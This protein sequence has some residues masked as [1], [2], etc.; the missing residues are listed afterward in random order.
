MQ[1]PTLFLPQFLLLSSSVSPIY[2]TRNAS[3]FK[4]VPQMHLCFSF[5]EQVGAGYH[6][7]I[8]ADNLLVHMLKGWHIQKVANWML[9]S[10]ASLCQKKFK[11]KIHMWFLFLLL[12][13]SAHR[14]FHSCTAFPSL[15]ES[16]VKCVMLGVGI[17]NPCESCVLRTDHLIRQ[18]SRDWFKFLLKSYM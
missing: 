6:C 17:W 12:D 1:A 4:C 11:C 14:S 7:H 10:V 18:W 3:S 16:P 15:T 5:I 9:P 8:A 2:W 13:H